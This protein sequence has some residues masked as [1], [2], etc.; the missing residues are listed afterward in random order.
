MSMRGLDAGRAHLSPFSSHL[1]QVNQEA[2][3]QSNRQHRLHLI[4][5]ISSIWAISSSSPAEDSTLHQPCT[6]FLALCN[7]YIVRDLRSSR[8]P[9]RT[10]AIEIFPIRRL[11]AVARDWRFRATPSIPTHCKKPR[12]ESLGQRPDEHCSV[13]NLSA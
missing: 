2:A 4:S 13:I 6:R 9:R 11:A 5:S 7:M 10:H 8:Q 1:Q 12:T 3:H